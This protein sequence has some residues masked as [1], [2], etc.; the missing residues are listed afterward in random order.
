MG[1]KMNKILPGLYL[2]GYRDM[3]DKEQIEKNQITHIL[4]IHELRNQQ[5]YKN[6][7]YYYI[8]AD[9]HDSQDLLQYIPSCNDFIHK[10]RN[11]GGNVL[12]HCMAGIS[13]SATLVIAYVMTVT[14][15]SF[16][17]AINAV[18]NAREVVD[19][20]PGFKKQLETYEKSESL[21]KEKQ[22]LIEKYGDFKDEDNKFSS[23]IT[24]PLPSNS[25][26]LETREFNK[27]QDNP[28]MKLE[29]DKNKNLTESSPLF[30][31]NCLLKNISLNNEDESNSKNE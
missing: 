13:R 20:N 17:D 19:P 10:A 23:E 8:K 16:Y 31:T 27:L 14:N 4:S 26:S 24:Y 28:F 30:L 18:K 22:N 3:K 2:G 15:L 21:K 5:L 29:K 12:V 6:V 9:D 7:K 11:E 1:A 25:Y